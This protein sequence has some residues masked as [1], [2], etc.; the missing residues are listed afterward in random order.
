M[1][2]TL[3]LSFHVWWN[4]ECLLKRMNV[5]CYNEANAITY[6]SLMHSILK[7]A[8]IEL[9][10]YGYIVHYKWRTFKVY[11]FNKRL[12][13][14]LILF[15]IFDDYYH[16]HHNHVTKR[17][18]GPSHDHQHRLNDDDRVHWSRQQRAKS[19]QK[20]DLIR[21]RP[22]KSWNG[23]QLNDPKWPLMWYLVCILI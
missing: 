14:F 15:Q 8:F 9:W 17:S 12:N 6:F 5:V 3:P 2:S 21:S 23:I 19:R 13:H 4:C 18:I 20:R 7:R 11:I 16:F 10:T 1:M 22:P